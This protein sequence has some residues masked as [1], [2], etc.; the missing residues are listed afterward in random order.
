MYEHY[1]VIS[2]INQVS[3]LICTDRNI[4][5]RQRLSY[6]TKIS[7]AV[8]VHYITISKHIIE[9][10]SLSDTTNISI[11]VSM[12]YV[13]TQYIN[14]IQMHSVSNTKKIIIAV[15]IHHITV[16]AHVDEGCAVG[17]SGVDTTIDIT[18]TVVG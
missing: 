16:V 5:Q 12:L 11:E 9:R 18:T 7:I 10:H 4:P 15:T 14:I 6:R 2:Q 8:S 13:T 3:I 17:V 1:L